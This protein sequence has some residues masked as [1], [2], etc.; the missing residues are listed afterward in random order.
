MANILI[1]NAL[2]ILYKSGTKKITVLHAN[3]E[4]QHPWKMLILEQ[5]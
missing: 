3:T 1:T 5:C 2:N 4:Y